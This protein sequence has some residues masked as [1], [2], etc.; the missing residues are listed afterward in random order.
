MFSFILFFLILGLLV[1]IHEFGHFIVAKKSGVRVEEFGFGFPPR[2]WGKKVGDTIYSVNAIPLGGFVKLY[3]EEYEEVAGQKKNSSSFVYKKPWVKTLIILAGVIMNAVLGVSIYYS[4]LTLN[5]FQSDPLPLLKPYHFRFGTQEGRVI[6]TNITSNS[7]AAKAGIQVE[8]IVQKF[9]IGSAPWKQITS[10][11]ELIN[12][13]KSSPGVVV[14]LDLEN[15][16]NGK[17]N[18]ISVVPIYN[19]ELKRAIIGVNLL[20]TVV[21]KYE[22]PKQKLLSG[23]MH[24]YNVLS[25]N[26]STIGELFKV[27]VKSKSFEPVS[28]TVSGPIGIFS[29]VDQIVKTS[30]EKMIKNILNIMAILSLSLAAMNV[31]PLPALDG[32]RLVFII[33]EWITGRPIHKKIEQYI[34]LGG[35]VLLIGLGILVSINDV[36]RLFR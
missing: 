19:A 1:L 12:I 29:I 5:H 4:L 26:Y 36:M 21:L 35:F 16:R 23:F 13:I 33:Y 22:T 27:A 9:Q 28:Q 2:L 34:N 11:S 20:D 30:G 7:P 18:I 15:V 3:G 17:K 10:S 24:S 31:L 8:D 25:Y 6:A 14:S 32:G